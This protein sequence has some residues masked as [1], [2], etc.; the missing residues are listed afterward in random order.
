MLDT[1]P[2]RI[3]NNLKIVNT[4]IDIATLLPNFRLKSEYLMEKSMFGV[5]P[6]VLSHQSQPRKV[7]FFKMTPERD[8]SY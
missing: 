6:F 7:R 5:I 3:T 8:I 4:T 2:K 1:F